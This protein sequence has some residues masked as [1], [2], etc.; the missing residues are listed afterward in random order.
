MTGIVLA[1]YQVPVLAD[2]TSAALGT[3]MQGNK[4]LRII[5]EPESGLALTEILA[6]ISGAR[7][8]RVSTAELV[9]RF[10]LRILAE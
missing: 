6:L 8:G 5:S 4:T 2:Q 10:N 7:A 9:E 1:P 3:F